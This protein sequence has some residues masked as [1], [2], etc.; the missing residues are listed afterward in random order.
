MYIIHIHFYKIIFRT[1][2]FLSLLIS[3]C[4]FSEICLNANNREF[5]AESIAT[6]KVFVVISQI[7]KAYE[8]SRDMLR[9]FYVSKIL[10]LESQMKEQERRQREI[11]QCFQVSQFYENFVMTI[12]TK[13]RERD[14]Q[15]DR[16]T[17]RNRFL[18]RNKPKCSSVARINNGCLTKHYTDDIVLNYILYRR[19]ECLRLQYKQLQY[20]I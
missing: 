3:N 11:K 12:S 6:D 1:S 5:D 16:Q 14:R 17:E 7:K 13:E 18:K 15:T 4:Y 2:L 8:N 19:T 10:F 20:T 9:L